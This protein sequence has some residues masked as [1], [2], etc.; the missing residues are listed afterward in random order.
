MPASLSRT[1]LRF[2]LAAGAVLAVT[3]L[4]SFGFQD[5]IG[6]DHA[7]VVGYTSMVLAFLLVYFGV[8]AHRDGAGGGRIGFWR[9]FGIGMAI[10]GVAT[11]CYVATWQFVYH[12]LAPDF[13]DRY[14]A[15]ALDKA[16]KAGASDAQLAATAKEMAEFAELYRNPLVNIGFTLLDP[17]PV[18]L[19]F[20]FV[21]AGLLSRRRA[22]PD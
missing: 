19:V 15:H 2:G 18:G 13:L 7:A 17:L 5:A 9:A 3:M 4:L 8:R 11:V 10:V 20:S 14:A 16:R 22:K 21:S 6:F 1:V 12:R